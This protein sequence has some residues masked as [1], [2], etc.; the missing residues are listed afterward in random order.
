MPPVRRRNW[1]WSIGLVLVSVAVATAV[2]LLRIREPRLLPLAQPIVPVDRTTGP[3][4][5]AKQSIYWI[6]ANAFLLVTTDYYVDTSKAPLVDG[7]HGHVDLITLPA[8]H[9]RR[10][11]GLTSVLNKPGVSPKGSP[12]DFEASPD[13]TWLHWL[14]WRSNSYPDLVGAAAKLDGGGYRE[15]VWDYVD[16]FWLDDHRVAEWYQ[17]DDFSTLGFSV[18]DVRY[19]NADC[20]YGPNSKQSQAI[21]RQHYLTLGTDRMAKV[22]SFDTVQCQIQLGSLS[23]DSSRVAIRTYLVVPPSNAE[24]LDTNVS[25]QASAI[26][27]HMK[28]QNT[29]AILAMLHRYV[30]AIPAKPILTEGLWISRVDGTGMTE[31]GRCEKGYGLDHLQWLPDNKHVSFVYRG[32]LYVMPADPPQ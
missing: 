6:S 10:M 24:V 12:A 29:P 27:W 31:L 21:F 19:P 22:S 23:E 5:Q 7:W 32:I 16:S 9:Q 13:G 28:T 25:P 4:G 2:M 26:V 20:H 11:V 15:W 3:D 18:H 30:A 17:D 8:R 14:N 1:T